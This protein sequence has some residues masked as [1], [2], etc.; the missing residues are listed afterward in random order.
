VVP[1]TGRRSRAP[2]GFSHLLSA[3]AAPGGLAPDHAQ[4]AEA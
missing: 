3:L 2:H 4:P 1:S